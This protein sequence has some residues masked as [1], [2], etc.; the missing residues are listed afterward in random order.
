MI[1]LVLVDHRH[2]I[3]KLVK[4]LA[5]VEHMC[6]RYDIELDV[7]LA[8][9]NKSYRNEKEGKKTNIILQTY[10]ASLQLYVWLL[11]ATTSLTTPINAMD[12]MITSTYTELEP[13]ESETSSSVK[14]LSNIR[15]ALL[16]Y[17]LQG[18]CI[19]F[20]HCPTMTFAMEGSNAV[21]TTHDM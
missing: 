1:I 18:S 3:T 6:C 11:C 16:E 12:E 15:R 21:G 19:Q 20:S 8:F 2:V 4:I 13:Q 9:M 10:I 14:E 17:K 7:A 5:A